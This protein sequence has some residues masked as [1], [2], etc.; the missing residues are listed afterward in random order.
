MSKWPPCMAVLR[1]V[2]APKSEK[3]HI[4]LMIV[5][6][7]VSQNP[8]RN[9]LTHILE[10]K[11]AAKFEMATILSKMVYCYGHLLSFVFPN[12]FHYMCVP[13]HYVC[14]NPLRQ[15]RT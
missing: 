6:T 13:F 14:E 8:L 10:S 3:W 11:M 2:F 9:H 15:L 4:F 5:I 12:N 7:Y 1:A